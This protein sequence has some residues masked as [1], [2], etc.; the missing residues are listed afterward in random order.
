[1]RLTIAKRFS[2]AALAVLFCFLM[3]TGE[4]RASEGETYQREEYITIEVQASDDN[5]GLQYAID[6]DAESAFSDTN[7][8]TI[9]AG[10][11]H[12]IY[13][14]DAAGNITSQTY[15][16]DSTDYQTYSGTEGEQQITIDLEMGNSKTED[17]S[18]YE[19]LTD[20]PVEAG[21]GTVRSKIKTDGTDSG[22][23]VFYTVSTDEGEVFYLVIDQSQS[24]DNVYLLN[25][26]TLD[27]LKGLAADSE[28]TGVS[29]SG[30][31]AEDNLLEALKDKNKAEDETEDKES[32]SGNKNKSLNNGL[33]M[34]VVIV[35]GGGAYYYLK[36]YK[37]KKDE[38]MD[39]MDA[40]NMDE[41]EVEDDE[42]G[43]EIE[44]EVDDEEKEKILNQLIEDDEE[45]LLDTDPETYSKA[46]NGFETGQQETDDESD[47]EDDFQFEDYDNE[48]ENEEE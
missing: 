42:E 25:T 13:V 15:G 4:V 44:F 5:E 48:E 3:F 32:S 21:T 29:G 14:K 40:M 47:L 46:Q 12:T 7:K 18:N 20:D 31:A 11:S 24:S 28:N 33:I 45:E 41:F 16:A 1:M 9:P 26:V 19:Y 38:M 34:L 43:D 39:T 8:F 6:S 36:V 30:E 2:K 23:R 10:T 27:D 17:Y 35:I 22:E 37:N